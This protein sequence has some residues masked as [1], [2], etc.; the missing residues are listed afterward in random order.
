MVASTRVGYTTSPP[1]QIKLFI[2]SAGQGVHFTKINGGRL[3]PSAHIVPSSSGPFRNSSMSCANACS[4][5]RRLV[6]P[7]RQIARSQ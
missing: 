6:G 4:G 1:R 5:P 3:T 7:L 2:S